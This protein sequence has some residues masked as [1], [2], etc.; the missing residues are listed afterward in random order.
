[1][2]NSKNKRLIGT[3]EIV[4]EIFTHHTDWNAAQVWKQYK[5]MVDPKN[6]VGLSAIQKHFEIVKKNYQEVLEKGLDNPWSMGSY[7]Q[8]G[9]ELQCK[10]DSE[11]NLNILKVRKMQLEKNGLSKRLSVRQAIWISRL[12]ATIYAISDNK[13]DDIPFRLWYVS[14]QYAIREKVCKLKRQVFYSRDLDD[15][16]IQGYDVFKDFCKQDV[17]D[18]WKDYDSFYMSHFL[19]GEF[20]NE[21]KEG[22]Q[23]ER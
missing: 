12:A 23:N 11:D 14:F 22:G 4:E 21:I 16:L 2:K 15:V 5:L 20:L 9:L 6:H 1:M 7:A 10:L 19:G 8:N 3:R 13:K 18:N 17:Y